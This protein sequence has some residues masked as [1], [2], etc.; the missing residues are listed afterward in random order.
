MSRP[1]LPLYL[2]IG[3]GEE[4]QIAVLDPAADSDQAA[5][6]AL[7]ALFRAAAAA[8]ESTDLAALRAQLAAA[9]EGEDGQLPAQPG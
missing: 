5:L 8:L 2:R 7:A 4:H 1:P 3:D 6:A 9:E